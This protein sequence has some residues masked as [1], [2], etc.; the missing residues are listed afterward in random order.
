MKAAVIG[1]SRAGLRHAAAYQSDTRAELVAVCD[2]AASRA[3]EAGATL[4]VRSF[5]AAPELLASTAPDICTVRTQSSRRGDDI[6]AALDSG[7]HV[8]SALPFSDSL[9]SALELA[10]CSRSKGLVLAGDFHLRFSSVM[11]KAAEWVRDGELGAPLF[12]NMNLWTRGDERGDQYE[13]LRNLAAHGIDMMRHLCGDVARVQCFGT[14][15]PEREFW[16]SAQANLQ[17]ASGA[18][19]N[20]TTSYDMV[21]QHPMARLGIAGTKARITVDNVYEEATLFIHGEKEKRVVSNSI[22]GGIPQ[23][24]ATYAARIGSLLAEIGSG[25]DVER[26]DGGICDAISAMRVSEAIVAALENETA[27]DITSDSGA[28]V[29]AAAGGDDT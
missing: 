14:K 2:P 29:A 20:L 27:V 21:P 24:D 26:I 12:A 17:F 8:L 4:G 15:A 11:D 7:A 5:T 16:S 10:D 19:G 28:P 9:S 23:L 3:E 1:L 22:W 6:A 13:L 25:V 18:V